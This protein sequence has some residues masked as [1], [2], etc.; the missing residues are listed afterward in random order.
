[1]RCLSDVAELER[2][3]S[4]DERMRDV[5]FVVECYQMVDEVSVARAMLRGVTVVH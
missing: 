4:S 5:R 2:R 3:S 1:M